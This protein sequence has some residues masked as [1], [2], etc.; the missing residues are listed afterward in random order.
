MLNRK[1]FDEVFWDKEPH[2]LITPFTDYEPGY[3][4]D[5]LNLYALFGESLL[6]VFNG[7]PAALAL[8]SE[9]D[10][11]LVQGALSTIRRAYGY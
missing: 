7:G 11:T 5:W 4:N 10:E 1:Q 9:S 2:L 8:S 6:L 3:Y